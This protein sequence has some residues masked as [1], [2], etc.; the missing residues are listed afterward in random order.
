MSDLKEYLKQCKEQIESTLEELLPSEKSYPE[1]IHALMRYS[2][3]A[4]GKRIRPALVLSAH[5]ACGGEF[6]HKNARY[7]GAALEM[8]HT[9][10]LIHDDLP[11]MDDDDY[12]RGKPTAHKAFSEALAVLGGDALCIYAYE[13]LGTV[14]DIEV[15]T[16]ISRALG[17]QGMIGGQVVDI[18]SEGK[19]VDLATVR[20]IH[21]N[22]TA[23]L[24][25]CSV[26]CGAVLAK[27]TADERE[28]MDRYG[29]LI[30]IAFQVIDDI[31]DITSST[32]VL[33]KDVGS[34][35]ARGKA[36]WPALTSLQE[37]RKYAHELTAE[38]RQIARSFGDSGQYLEKIARYLEERI[39]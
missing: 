32:E 26:L 23:A 11:C 18:E 17:T 19:E 22:K 14:G 10:S 38:A 15:I 33:G 28:R 4:G 30:G 34:D 29:D 13:I 8:L 9:F 20:Y 3:F 12:R 16:F 36:T 24:I 31:L 37:S 35:V 7:V 6:A 2:M 27:A 1:S 5:S 39:N 25:R 21:A